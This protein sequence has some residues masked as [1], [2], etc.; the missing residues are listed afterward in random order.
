MPL[1]TDSIQPEYVALEVAEQAG[2]WLR[3]RYGMVYVTR[4]ETFQ[5]PYPSSSTH[6]SISPVT[7]FGVGAQPFQPHNR[8]ERTRWFLAHVALR[9]AAQEVV[10]QQ[11][12]VVPSRRLGLWFCRILI[13]LWSFSRSWAFRNMMGMQPLSKLPESWISRLIWSK[14][15]RTWLAPNA[16]F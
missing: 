4:A 10:K 11:P 12:D 15:R 5:E 3:R 16:P 2:A 8:H 9:M 14:A 13:L 7:F 6:C 1:C